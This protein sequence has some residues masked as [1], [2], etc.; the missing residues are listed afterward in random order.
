[1]KARTKLPTPAQTAE[2]SGPSSSIP[3]PHNN[4]DVTPPI[5]APNTHTDAGSNVYASPTGEEV[6]KMNKTQLKAARKEASK[7]EELAQFEAEVA[8]VCASFIC[9]YIYLC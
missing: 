9:I 8:Q 2:T 3:E 6:S 1:M 5:P 4:L 7:A